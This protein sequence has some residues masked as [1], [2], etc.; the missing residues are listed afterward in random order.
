M[1]TFSF[2]TK[3][4]FP[5]SYSLFHLFTL[6]EKKHTMKR[7]NSN[8]NGAGGKAKKRKIK[9]EEGVVKQEGG[10][11]T[12]NDILSDS[13]S[14]S[15]EQSLMDALEVDWFQPGRVRLLTSEHFFFD[16]R[17][18]ILS[19]EGDGGDIVIFLQR[20]F[21]VY[22]NWILLF[23]ALLAKKFNKKLTVAVYLPKQDEIN[24][25][26]SSRYFRFLLQGW[27]EMKNDLQSL[28]INFIMLKNNSNTNMS[29]NK[30]EKKKIEW[31][32]NMVF[33]QLVEMEDLNIELMIMDFHP[34]KF[35]KRLIE[36]FANRFEKEKSIA[37]IM[38]DS[39]NIVPAWEASDKEEHMAKTI[40]PKITQKLNKYLTYFPSMEDQKELLQMNNEATGTKLN[41]KIIEDLIQNYFTCPKIEETVKLPKGGYSEG[42]KKLNKI[43]P[44]DV[45]SNSESLTRGVKFVR[46]FNEKR[47]DPSA[48]ATTHLSPY[49]N[50]GFLST[51]TAALRVMD[52][53]KALKNGSIKGAK[54]AVEGCD[55]L[56]EQLIIRRELTDN[57]CLHNSKYDQ[58]QGAK[59]WARDS[60]RLHNNDPREKEYTA[61]EMDKGKTHDDVWNA[62]QNELTSLGHM[63]GYLRMYWAKQ[64]LQWTGPNTQPSSLISNTSSSS[65]SSSSSSNSTTTNNNNSLNA[66]RAL[67][68]AILFNDRY[69][70]DGNDP[71]GFVGCIWSIGGIHDQGWK[72]RQVS[73][74]IRFMNYNGCKRKFS[75][76]NYIRR[77][78]NLIKK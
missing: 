24:N 16:D 33:D 34:L 50:R 28:G 46:R 30:N 4:F 14:E 3:N 31:E 71:N 56:H 7:E 59:Q 25:R 11:P 32:A 52:L 20:D 69:A 76:P 23:S 44:E 13:N 15:R 63:P 37:T 75:I 48:D 2:C 35:Q 65:S 18:Q 55:G 45:S 54:E 12:L 72:E 29:N 40:R 17:N 67:Q 66:E 8:T 73:G 5:S 38:V 22:D 1:G 42:V 62:A 78:N 49:F 47:N 58:L 74:K 39:H 26:L 70:L 36:L 53:R 6:Q 21:R 10:I 43:L 41:N 9:E 61:S 19:Q 68:L 51:Q 27:E 60:L 64:I 57:Y 77:V